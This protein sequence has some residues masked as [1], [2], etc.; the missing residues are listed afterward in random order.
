MSVGI[1][2]IKCGMTRQFQEDG[3]SV[4]VTVVLANPNRIVQVKT[5]FLRE[6]GKTDGYDALQVSYGKK[7]VSR[8][9]KPTL[10]HSRKANTEPGLGLYEFR[11]PL[12]KI[13]ECKANGTNEL[14]VDQFQVG[15]VVDVTGV[16]KGK[17]FAGV[18][19]RH[20]FG[21][22]DATHGNSLS[23]RAHGSTGQ[24]QSPGRVFK[25]KKM[26]GRMG[27]DKCTIQNISIVSVDAEK[28]LITLRGGLPGAP[29]S[30][31]VIKPA[32]KAVKLKV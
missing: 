11:L 15:Q 28:N 19:K 13:E 16:S 12:K 3:S 4:P 27:G 1:V 29:G 6:N 5:S 18:I 26:A 7:K 9:N 30:V 23:H 31:L 8:V 25:N 22:Q 17:G 24:R 2:A 10:G 32:I 21:M 20:H 14:K